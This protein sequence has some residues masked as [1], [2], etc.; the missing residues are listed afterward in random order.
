MPKYLFDIL[1]VK[2]NPKLKSNWEGIEERDLGD[3]ESNP[4]LL[5]WLYEKD[6]QSKQHWDQETSA[7]LTNKLEQISMWIVESGNFTF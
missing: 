5:D 3:L 7:Y 2:E 6:L 1:I 4:I